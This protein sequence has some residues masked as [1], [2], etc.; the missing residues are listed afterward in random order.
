VTVELIAE[1]AQGYEGD[2]AKAQLLVKGA[3]RT[4]A[5][6]VKFQLIYADEIGTPDY[7]HYKLF[8]AL[9]MPQKA[10]RKVA[11]DIKAG[12]AKLYFDVF[13]ERSLQEAIELGA[14]GV[15]IHTTDFYNTRLIRMALDTL[16][17]VFISLGGISTTE[18]EEFIDFYKISPN[19]QVCFMYGF[20]AE[21][22]PV[23]ANNF[24][25]L[26]TLKKY[27]PDH[28][29]GFMDHT[30]GDSDDALFLALVTLAFGIVCIE[31]HISL[32]RTL[33]LED[34]VSA[35]APQKF[36]G[37]V[38]RVRWSE[39]ALWTGRLEIMPME[40]EYRRKAMKVVVA[41]QM[42]HRGQVLEEDDL[43][44]KRA[45]NPDSISAFYRLEQVV[46]RTL[47]HDL[48]PNQQILEDTLQ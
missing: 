13:G 35:L 22:T 25:G 27:F 46:G 18:L 48:Q 8:S 39:K 23:E 38:Q 29:F 37:F 12:E 14:D 6:A 17:R 4:G 34:Y 31:K 19:Q 44:L 43:V 3:V 26:E 9:E 32:D 47:V 28:Q 30:A 20:Q 2:I 1:V 15:K 5:D 36:Q 41:N 40:R 24:R 42:L 10:W 7:Q 33:Q 16:P 21:P 45:A 11:D